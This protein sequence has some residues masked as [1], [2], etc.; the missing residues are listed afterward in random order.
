MQSYKRGENRLALAMIAPSIIALLVIGLYPLLFALNISARTYMLTRQRDLG[1]FIGLENYLTVLGDDLFWGAMGRT[2][3]LFIATIPL[4]LVLGIGVALVLNSTRWKRLA[5]V[6]RVALVLPFATTPAVIG[7]VFRLVYNSD[8]GLLNYVL[9]LIGIG[10]VNWLGDPGWA[11]VAIVFVELWQWMPFVALVMLSS[12][13]LVPEDSIDAAM[14][15]AGSWWTIFRH[16]QLPFMMPGITA[17]LILRTADILKL[18]DM[19]F[20]LTR[21][22]PGVSTELISLYIQRVGFRVFDMGVA[23]AQAILLLILCIVLSR[24]YISFFYREVE[25]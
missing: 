13:T 25:I 24:A 2:A 9:S 10:P 23:S 22:G 7:L 6:L 21:G 5:G 11:M 4:Q 17:V 19:P 16:I 8:F 1:E 15:D 12:L 20:V 18:F 3:E 14:L